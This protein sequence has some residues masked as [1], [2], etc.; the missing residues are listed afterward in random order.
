MSFY[1]SNKSYRKRDKYSGIEKVAYH[2]GVI[3][4]VIKS[5]KDCR[6]RDSYFNGKNG[7]KD[8]KPLI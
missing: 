3:E 2:L 4:N 7:K 1:N 8:R 6:V 5:N